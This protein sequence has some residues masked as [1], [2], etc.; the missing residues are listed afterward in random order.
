MTHIMSILRASPNVKIELTAG[1]LCAF[2][3][4]I[5]AKV[6]EEVF[7]VPEEGFYSVNEVMK[8]Y[9]IKARSTLYKWDKRGYLP[10]EKTG[11]RIQYQKGLVHK[12]LGNPKYL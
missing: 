8:I 7:K 5:V 3:D 12:V 4:E 1:E 10:C 2:A 6:K 11:N 9:G